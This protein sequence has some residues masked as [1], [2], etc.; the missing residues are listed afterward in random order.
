MAT[1]DE[2]NARDL[3]DVYLREMKLQR[4]NPDSTFTGT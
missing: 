3:I 2:K 1:T 4:N